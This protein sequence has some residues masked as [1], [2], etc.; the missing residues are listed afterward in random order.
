MIP[1]PQPI[2]TTAASVRRPK[3]LYKSP[4]HKPTRN[5]HSAYDWL[6]PR[7]NGKYGIRPRT[8]PMRIVRKRSLCSKKTNS[9]S[10]RTYNGLPMRFSEKKLRK[11]GRGRKSFVRRFMEGGKRK[12]FVV[13]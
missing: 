13:Y 8:A 11:V 10:A 5:A 4:R 1:V 2:S 12:I 7:R 3:Y 9:L 6:P